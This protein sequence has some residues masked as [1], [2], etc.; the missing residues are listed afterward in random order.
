LEVV[1]LAL[2]HERA[3]REFLGEFA[4]AGEPEIPAFLVDPGWPHPRIVETLAQWARGEGLK[5][6]WVPCTTFFLTHEGRVLGVAT[7][8][9]RLTDFLWEYGG[10]VGY[11]VRPSDRGRGH[12]TRLLEAVK[13]RARGMGIR[14]LLATCDVDNPAS[15]R[16]IEKCGGLFEDE[17]F[18]EAMSRT[19]HRYW[20][21]TT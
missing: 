16:V 9:H 19:V 1:Q 7:L 4:D 13:E 17:S 12:A 6:G 10:H 2:E 15:A 11:S 5:E 3:L 18:N 14:R 20:I 8:R 21:S